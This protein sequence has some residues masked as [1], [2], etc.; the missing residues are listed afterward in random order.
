MEFLTSVF[1]PKAL[2]P[3]FCV[4]DVTTRKMTLDFSVFNRDT[5]HPDG[6]ARGRELYLY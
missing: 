5:Y 1:P 2:E 6:E 4:Y 3:W